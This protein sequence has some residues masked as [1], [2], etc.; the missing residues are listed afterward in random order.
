VAAFLF[1]LDE[2]E[3]VLRRHT[4]MVFRDAQTRRHGSDSFRCVTACDDDVQP[5][6]TQGIN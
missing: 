1:L 2:F 4:G 6:L 3:L 5:A